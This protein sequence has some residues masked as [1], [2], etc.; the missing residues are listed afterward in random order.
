MSLLQTAG[1]LKRNALGTSFKD[2]FTLHLHKPNTLHFRQLNIC[3]LIQSLRISQSPTAHFNYYNVLDTLWASWNSPSRGY[4][5]L[6]HPQF[7]NYSAC[8]AS[9]LK[10]SLVRKQNPLMQSSKKYV[11]WRVSCRASI[12]AK[13]HYSTLL[14]APV[15]NLTIWLCAF[16]RF[17]FSSF[18]FILENY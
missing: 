18:F 10:L 2:V 16:A 5:K 14:A 1:L 7:G 6:L 3:L 9:S 8:S 15:S 11:F 17:S 12:V 13:H 4:A